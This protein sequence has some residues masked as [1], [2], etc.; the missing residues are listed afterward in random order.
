MLFRIFGL[1]IIYY[2]SNTQTGI[3]DEKICGKHARS[4]PCLEDVCYCKDT[5]V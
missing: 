5:G 3:I 1:E 4:W 2:V